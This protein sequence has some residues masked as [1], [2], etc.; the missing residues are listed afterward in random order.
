[1]Q[2]STQMQLNGKVWRERP[3]GWDRAGT[4]LGPPPSTNHLGFFVS[5]HF[6]VLRPWDL[7]SVSMKWEI[8]TQ[9]SCPFS[10]LQDLVPTP[11]HRGDPWS[12]APKW[13]GSRDHRDKKRALGTSPPPRRCP[14][15]AQ[16]KVTHLQ[17]L[18]RKST[19]NKLLTARN[20]GC[21]VQAGQEP[22][23]S[24]TNQ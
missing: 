24:K 19:G 5:D 15:H 3:Q 8:Q 1:M 2:I 10:R 17:L 4:R 6:P 23:D 20:K 18:S 11:L 14:T 16:W 12:P 9:W 7:A 22:V 21:L 13:P